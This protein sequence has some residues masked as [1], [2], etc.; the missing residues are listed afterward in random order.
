M[1][2]KKPSKQLPTLTNPAVA[3]EIFY[4]K[5]AIDQNGEILKGTVVCPTTSTAA[6]TPSLSGDNLVID[7]GTQENGFHIA[8]G[9]HYG[10]M[11]SVASV[12]AAAGLGAI[13]T[14]TNYKDSTTTSL[15][16]PEIVGKQNVLISFYDAF[17]QEG[18]IVGFEQINGIVNSWYLYDNGSSSGEV[19]VVSEEDACTYDPATGTINADGYF[20]SGSYTYIAW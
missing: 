8:K 1:G 15:T 9:G 13:V 10:L 19:S 6:G 18:K 16:I 20:A 3:D 12:A 7:S 5:E 4:N 11:A 14:G 2:L 17:K